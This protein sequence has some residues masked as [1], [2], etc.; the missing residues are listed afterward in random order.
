M[1]IS[2]L[3][4]ASRVVG[5]ITPWV[6]FLCAAVLG[7]ETYF[8]DNPK[9]EIWFLTIDH[10]F[11]AYFAFELTV[12]LLSFQ[13]WQITR[14]A[15]TVCLKEKHPSSE[16][17]AQAEEAFWLV[18]DAAIL[19]FGLL[20]L[21]QEFVDH[22]E[23]AMTLRLF[24]IFRVF[25][26]FEVSPNLKEIER[27]IASV[28]PTVLVFALL[29]GLILFVYAIVGMNLYEFKKFGKLDFSTLYEA[30]ASLFSL[31]SNGWDDALV[32]LKAGSPQI[33]PVITDLYIFSFFVFSVL[34]TLNVFVS[35]MAGQVQ[36]KIEEKIENEIHEL[37]SHEQKT[38]ANLAELRKEIAELKAL[39]LNAQGLGKEG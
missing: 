20:S 14:K 7:L 6:I 16:Y 22:P 11:L 28:V 19:L 23:L 5:K 21:L 36:A 37:E 17:I 33:H 24:R 35:V 34:V 2:S 30:F 4:S 12:R 3:K 15:I 25:R 31:M 9:V 13:S 10:L 39:L 29:L 27:K 32:E 8:R 1:E 38:A 18:F 26:L